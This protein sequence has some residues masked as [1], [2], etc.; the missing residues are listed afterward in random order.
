MDTSLPLDADDVEAAAQAVAGHVLR[1]P[2]LAAPRLS[3]LSGAEVCVKYENLQVTGAFKE[4]GAVNRLARLQP[5]EHRRGVVTFSAGN[6]AQ[7]LACH[8]ARMQVPATIV[9]PRTTPFVK[10]ANTEA[11]GAKVVLE[12]ETVA[13]CSEVVTGLVESEGLTLV[14]PYDDPLVMAGQ[15]TLALEMLEDVSEL[16]CIVVPIGGGGLVSGIAVAARARRPDI[17]I[18]GVQSALYPSMRAALR[19]E[20]SACGGDTLA[21]GIAVKSVSPRTL[22][23]IEAL[24]SDVLAVEEAEIEQAIY[25]YLIHQKTLAEGAG[26]AALAALLANRERFRGRRVGLVLSGGNID[27]RMVSAITV[28]AL[29]RDDRIVALRIGLRDRPGELARVSA[30]LGRE[31]ANILEVSHHRMLLDVPA[32]RAT[33]DITVET[34]D[35]RHADAV[36]GALRDAGIEVRRLNPMT[37]AEANA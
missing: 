14:H 26:A 31:G 18:V 4:R 24:V 9:M 13:E 37:G 25:A 30:V 2:C 22:A 3:A 34:R 5:D 15:G 17:D 36:I 16:D 1:T 7:A 10:V 23:V 12:G 6:H 32:M 28:R 33:A 29:E 19:E 27:T 21:E 20:T 11:Y 8:A 35:R